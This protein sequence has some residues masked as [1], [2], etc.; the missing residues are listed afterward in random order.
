M[1]I[2]GTLSEKDLIINYPEMTIVGILRDAELVSKAN[3]DY[4]VKIEIRIKPLTIELRQNGILYE[5]KLIYCFVKCQ[6]GI[7]GAIGCA[8]KGVAR[9]HNYISYAQYLELREIELLN[10]KLS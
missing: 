9:T 1:K 5:T 10:V 6:S 3:G 8:I 2:N 4:I 7:K